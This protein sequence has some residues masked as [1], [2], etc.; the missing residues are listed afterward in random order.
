MKHIKNII[1]TIGIIFIVLSC[2]N[3]TE[4]PSMTAEVKPK[5]NIDSIFRNNLLKSENNKIYLLSYKYELNDT[6]VREIIFKYL[7]NY[8]PVYYYLMNSEK[9][10]TINLKH[11]F[12][13]FKNPTNMKSLIDTISIDYDVSKKR[14]LR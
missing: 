7:A 5:Q 10:D 12:D 13:K 11:I 2:Q 4:K 1:L 6:I 9:L 14:F 3:G 8:S